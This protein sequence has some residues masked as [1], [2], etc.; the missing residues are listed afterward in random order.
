VVDNWPWT[1]NETTTETVNENVTENVVDAIPDKPRPHDRMR[2]LDAN[3]EYVNSKQAADMI[4]ITQNNL[5]Q[6]VFKKK[7]AVAEKV[8]RNTY[9]RTTDINETITQRKK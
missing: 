6:L 4:G 2:E 8:G 5:R 3:P 9:Y 1:T 7:L